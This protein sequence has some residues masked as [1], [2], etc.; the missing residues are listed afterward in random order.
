MKAWMLTAALM[1]TNGVVYA[2]AGHGEKP[3][4]GE[5]QVK[6]VT[7][8][9]AKKKAL[10]EVQNLISGGKIDKAWGDKKPVKAFKKKW[11]EEIEWAVTF[12]DPKAA[13][14]TR[15]TLFIF[16]SEEDRYVTYNYTGL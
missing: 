12:E 16:V 3:K 4:P 15:K 11:G 5:K 8:A 13:D 9:E 10:A 2:H 6:K 1:L 7:E 14:P